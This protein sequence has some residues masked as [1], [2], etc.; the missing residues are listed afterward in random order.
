MKYIVVTGG[1]LSGLGKGVV[2]AS[3]GRI[4][5]AMNFNVV[6]IKIDGYVNVDPGTMNPYEH[7]EVYVLQDGGETDLD[8]GHYERFMNINL[9]GTSNITTGKI[10][11]SVIDKERRGDY[12]GKTVQIIPHITDE[13]EKEIEKLKSDIVL[14]EVGGTVGDIENM[15]FLEGLRQ[16]SIK[17]YNE[18]LFIHLSY[19]P[20]VTTG[21]QKTKPTQHSAKEL[22]GLGIRP[23]IIIGR[24]EKSLTEETRKKI[25]MFCGVDEN[26]VM[27]NPNVD[28]IYQ[29]PIILEEQNLGS[30]ICDKLRLRPTTPKLNEWKN[31]VEKNKNLKY[32][33]DIG[34]VG[35]YTGLEDAY[36]SIKESFKHAGIA[37]NC[38]V[39]LRWFESREIDINDLENIDGILVPGGFGM[40]GLEGKIK[41]VK[42]ARENNIPF[43]GICLGMHVAIIEFAR[44]FGL[45]ANTT[46]IETEI[47]EKVEHPVIDILP[48]QKKIYK[49]GGTMRLGAYPCVLEKG[50]I[51][52]KLYK[53]PK[54]YERHRH[55]YEVNPE[56]IEFL[57]SKGL[58]FSGK[59]PDGNLMEIVELKNHPYFIACQ[60][61]PE[62][63]SR[64]EDPAPLFVGLVYMALR[65][66]LANE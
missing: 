14:V 38:K 32:E 28:D 26:C 55:R 39:N 66:K 18:F 35:K 58:K 25:A 43:L 3:I 44:A 6:P 13:I 65:R 64:L 12:L 19:I 21:E 23:E 16:M 34:I 63:Q 5:K 15:V 53:E 48:E 20:I 2:V 36:L 57:E 40:R 49:K 11:K 47:N 31:F 24:C 1:V 9:D 42:F 41:A 46:E 33:I 7:G 17:D 27:S 4:L 51:A 8:L 37:N 60:F 52:H 62:Y 10:Y 61:H 45:N 22:L 30:L 56:Y 29:I 50:T 54:I 59:S